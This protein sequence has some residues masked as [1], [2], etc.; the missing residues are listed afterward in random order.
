MLANT[1][2]GVC[3]CPEQKHEMTFNPL[4]FW[5][6]TAGVRSNVSQIG[7]ETAEESNPGGQVGCCVGN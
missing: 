6:E 3:A 5:L 4:F 2:V 1:N 7:G